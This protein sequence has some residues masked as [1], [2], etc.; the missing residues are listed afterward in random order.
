MKGS[1]AITYT[2]ACETWGKN[3]QLQAQ[4]HYKN[5]ILLCQLY[6]S[7]SVHYSIALLL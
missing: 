7:L 3:N 2:A 5:L 4:K 1:P 6:A